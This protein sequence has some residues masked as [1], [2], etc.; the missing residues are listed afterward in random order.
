MGE[1]MFRKGEGISK[2]DKKQFK[3]LKLSM[4]HFLLLIFSFKAI[5]STLIHGFNV[6]IFGFKMSKQQDLLNLF[7]AMYTAVFFLGSTNATAVPSLLAI[8]R[9]VFYRERAAGMNSELPYAFSQVVEISKMD[10]EPSNMDIL[11][12]NGITSSN[13]L[14]CMDFSFPQSAYGS[15]PDTADEHEPIFFFR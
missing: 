5:R 2:Y 12:A 15:N 6:F 13:G 7:G 10:Y 11:Y 14:A 3:I 9:T 8:E 4:N 1:K